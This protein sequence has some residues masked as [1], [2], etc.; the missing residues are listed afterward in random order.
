M[1]DEGESA[2]QG[3][4]TVGLG[5]FYYCGPVG[6]TEFHQHYAVQI[7]MP[8]SGPL[9][10]EIQERKRT[11]ESFLVIGSNVRHR[12]WSPSASVQLLYIEP[13]L[14]ERNTARLNVSDVSILDL[15]SEQM[16]SIKAVLDIDARLITTDLGRKIVSLI[17]PQESD[18]DAFSVI[19]PRISKSL[20]EIGQAEDLNLRLGQVIQSSGLSASRFRHLFR[21]QVGMSL[22]S[23][24]L[25]TK[26]QRAIQSLATDSSLTHAAHLAGFSDSA[27][28]SRTF[29]Q[30]FGFAPADLTRNAQFKLS[31]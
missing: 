31:P 30:T 14:L 15:S 20:I 11:V 21:T 27:H 6:D 2:W 4:L 8:F 26:L 3:E 24:L 18:S 13:N 25:W 28:L 16:M 7:C 5:W 9:Q 29:R 23:Y 10:I 12:I 1:Q 22:K 17:W 19:D